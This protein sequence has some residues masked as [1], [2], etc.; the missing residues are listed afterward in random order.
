M[1]RRTEPKRGRRLTPEEEALWRAATKDARP[2]ARSRPQPPASLPPAAPPPLP[3]RAEVAPAPKALRSAPPA[4]IAVPGSRREPRPG[5]DS[6]TQR[7][8]AR[9]ELPI[10]GRI[11]LHG[12]TLAEAHP[13]LRHYLSR[14]QGAGKRCII[15]ITGKGRGGEGAIRRAVPRWLAEAPNRALVLAHAPARPRD[16]GEGALYLLLRRR[17]ERGA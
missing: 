10:E 13:A 9:G 8:L 11:D 3:A 2:L 14:A 17:R 16:G 12:M 1:T 6:A 15:V 4:P 5:L 7:R